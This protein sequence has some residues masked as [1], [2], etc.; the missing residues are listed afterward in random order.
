MAVTA[1]LHGQPQPMLTREVDG[2]PHVGRAARLHHERGAP[3]DTG[4]DHATCLLVARLPWQQQPAAQVAFQLLQVAVGECSRCAIKGDGAQIAR[5]RGNIC[6]RTAKGQQRAGGCRDGNAEKSTSIHDSPPADFLS[7]WRSIALRRWRRPAHGWLLPCRSASH[8]VDR[9]RSRRLRMLL[10][11]NGTN[12]FRGD[13]Y[14]RQEI[15]RARFSR[16]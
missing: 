15:L 10:P 13:L 1:A 6:K 12:D 9:L 3:V 4:V 2:R 5:R 8:L 7:S 16:A 11:V 14:G